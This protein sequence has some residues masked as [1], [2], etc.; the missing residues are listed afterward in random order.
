MRQFPDQAEKYLEW[1]WVEQHKL[2]KHLEESSPALHSEIPQEKRDS[3][4]AEYQR[5]R[6]FF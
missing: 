4:E 6:P 1:Q 3:D 2:H 5:V